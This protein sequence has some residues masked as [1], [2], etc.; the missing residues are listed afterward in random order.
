M[1]TQVLNVDV[2]NDY[3][4][5]YIFSVKLN[6]VDH[7]LSIPIEIVEDISYSKGKQMFELSIDELHLLAL[8]RDKEIGKLVIQ[9]ELNLII[10]SYLFDDE[11]VLSEDAKELRELLK[12]HIYG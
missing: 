1:R 3:C 7:T 5:M 10:D 2:L 8:C 4:Y 11:Y 6:G 12:R 9:D